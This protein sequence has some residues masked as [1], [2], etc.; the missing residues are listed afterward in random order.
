MMDKTT[1][2]HKIYF[3]LVALYIAQSIPMSFFTSAM[4]AIMRQEGYS[5]ESIGIL[6]LV[7]LPWILKV[8]WA[9]LVDRKALDIS[10]LRK[11]IISSEIF[12]AGIVFIISFFSLET[13]FIQIVLLI[14]IAITASATQDI[15]TDSYS[16]RILD[17]NKHCIGAGMQSMGGFLGSLAGGGLLL[18][19]FNWFG[20]KSLTVCLSLFVLASLIPLVI[21]GE[22]K[23]NADVDTSIK[24]RISLK[25]LLSYFKQKNIREHTLFLILFSSSIMIVLAMLRPYLIDLEQSI[26]Q[27]GIIMG[28]I[29][30]SLAAITS[31]FVGVF[32]RKFGKKI[33]LIACS[34]LILIS[35]LFIFIVSCIEVVPIGVVYTMIALIWCTHGSATVI[36]YSIAMGRV[37]EGRSATDFTLQTVLVQLSGLVLSVIGGLIAGKF[38]YR[39][40]FAVGVLLA[41]SS[42]IYIIT[43]YKKQFN[44]H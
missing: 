2:P 14:V 22:K 7:K 23:E 34:L 21:W 25:D 6:Q 24:R 42:L 17:K 27:I 18:I 41:F 9:P 43:I 36:L 44:D 12:Y 37:R 29:G 8:L 10:S 32:I 4:P 19:I 11:W 31:F 15:C 1:N 38:S 33:S 28:I 40:L 30:T 3:T 20:W 35:V 26:Y 39:F 13:N 5:L 16:I